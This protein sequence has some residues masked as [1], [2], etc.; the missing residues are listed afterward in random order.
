MI[1]FLNRRST[2]ELLSGYCYLFFLLSTLDRAFTPSVIFQLLSL[3]NSKSSAF[4]SVYIL[5]FIGHSYTICF[6]MTP[7][8]G[9]QAE[10]MSDYRRWHNHLICDSFLLFPVI[11]NFCLW[12]NIKCQSQCI[13]ILL[14]F[15]I[16]YKSFL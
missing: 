8:T 14:L 15:V 6:P 11:C 1:L 10:S 4:H 2:A 16:Q 13:L 7:H 5:Y 12:F 3:T 9:H